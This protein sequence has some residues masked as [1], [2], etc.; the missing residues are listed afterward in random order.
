LVICIIPQIETS[1]Q[2]LQKEI[3]RNAIFANQQ[4]IQR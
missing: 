3:D 4:A 1:C 2:G